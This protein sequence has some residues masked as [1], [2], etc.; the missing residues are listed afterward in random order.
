MPGIIRV[1][2]IAV[3]VRDL[4]NMRAFYVEKLGGR[5]GSLYHNARTGFRSYFIAFSEGA[6]IEL[7]N[8]SR[9]RGH[10]DASIGYAHV[11]LSAGG[12]DEVDSIIRTLEASG[13]TVESRPRV[14]GDGYYE[15]VVRDPEGNRIEI[16]A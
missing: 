12:R 2:H 13:V 6:R 1:D 14:T 7:M 9:D 3:W 15:A 4:E 16:T 5:S 8:D 10:E 11:A